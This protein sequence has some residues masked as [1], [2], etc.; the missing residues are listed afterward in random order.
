MSTLKFEY[1]LK[2][3]EED[4][5]VSEELALPNNDG[6]SRMWGYKGVSSLVLVKGM[7]FGGKV[8]L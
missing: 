1:Y 2:Q 4:F 8:Y 5:A 3:G 6:R 7:W